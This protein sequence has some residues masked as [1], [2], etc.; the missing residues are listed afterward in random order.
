MEHV[1]IRN[2]YD[3]VIDTLKAQSKVNQRS[4]EAELRYM[5]AHR[6]ELHAPD[7]LLAEFANTIWEKAR[8]T[9]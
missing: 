1:T 9:E 4:L 3:Q 8:R 2:L 5:L 6:L 7:I